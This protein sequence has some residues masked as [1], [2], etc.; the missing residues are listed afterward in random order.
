M[1]R[2]QQYLLVFFLLMLLLLVACG[3]QNQEESQTTEE[4]SATEET[5][6]TEETNEPIVVEG[7]NGDVTIP[8]NLDKIIAPYMEDSLLA[9]VSHRQHNGQSENQFKPIYKIN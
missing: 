7:Q 3:G 1:K 2:I 8:A 6:E 5:K 4:D 9:W